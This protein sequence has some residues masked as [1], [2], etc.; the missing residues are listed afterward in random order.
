MRSFNSIFCYVR[1]G[2]NT[3]MAAVINN[4]Y[5]LAKILRRLFDSLIFINLFF[6]VSVSHYFHLSLSC[7]IRKKIE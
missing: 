4:F 5:D 3:Y 2:Y 7:F 6:T 1:V